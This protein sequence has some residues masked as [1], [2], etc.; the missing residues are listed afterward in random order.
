MPAIAGAALLSA[1]KVTALPAETL[2]ILLAG[3]TAAAVVG[4]LALWMLVYVV[5]KGNLYMFAPY[6][7]AVA[8]LALTRA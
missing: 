5:R 2:I 4:Y 7:F 3:M 8:V 6:C 1:R